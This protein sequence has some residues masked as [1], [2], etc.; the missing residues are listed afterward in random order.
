MKSNGNNE[1]A[2]KT[3]MGKIAQENARNFVS[4]LTP[5]SIAYTAPWYQWQKIATFL[6][7]MIKAP[8]TELE[9]LAVP[10]A[11]DLI[12][13]LIDLKVI[14]LTKDALQIYPPLKEKLKDNREWLYKNNKNIKL[15]LFAENDPFS[16]IKKPN[17]FGAAINYNSHLSFSGVAQGL[18]HR[19]IDFQ[20]QV[21]SNF[22]CFMPEFIKG[23]SYEREFLR[24]YTI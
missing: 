11:Q 2:A 9:R 19:T 7:E 17:D 16:G 23:T 20:I 6:K 15:S 12:N 24:L 10:Y 8:Q 14:V 3:N 5:T 22:S 21:P 13:Q 4:V 18:R 1:N